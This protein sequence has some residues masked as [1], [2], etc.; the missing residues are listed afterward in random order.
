MSNPITPP[1]PLDPNSLQGQ[2]LIA[3]PSLDDP[4]FDH[5]VIYVCQHDE[6]SAMGLVLNHPIR[7]LDFGRMLDELGI[8]MTDGE[9]ATQKIFNG[10]PVQNDRGFVLHS[11]DYCLKDITL[12]LTRDGEPAPVSG[13]GL[14]ATRDILV[15][16]SKGEGPQDAVIALGYAGWTAGQLEEEIRQNVWLIAPA[17]KAI[18]FTNTPERMWE[19]A[20]SSL[21]I[22]QEHLSTQS[23]TA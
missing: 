9:R 11:L 21:G 17:D 7:G 3:M 6:D 18:I 10:G 16:L 23:G 8:E 2:L 13:L 20:L 5:S 12:R 22:S 19:K 14:T 4:N 1:A 15:D